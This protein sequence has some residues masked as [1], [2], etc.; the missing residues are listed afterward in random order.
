[1]SRSNDYFKS[2]KLSVLGIIGKPTLRLSKKPLKDRMAAQVMHLVSYSLSLDAGQG[3]VPLPK[4]GGYGMRWCAEH[5][6]QP[7]QD[8]IGQTLT[9]SA[10][11]N[12]RPIPDS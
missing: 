4:S 7:R 5:G 8:L 3:D 1:M 11:D 10:S 6:W 2:I 12:D 9:R